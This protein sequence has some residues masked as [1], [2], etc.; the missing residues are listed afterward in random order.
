MIDEKEIYNL[1]FDLTQDG[2]GSALGISR[3]HSSSELKKLRQNGKIKEKQ[4]R[5]T[6]SNVRRKVYYLEPGGKLEAESIEKELENA[7]ISVETVLDMRRCDPEL[8]WEKLSESDRDALGLACVIRVP[9]YR[10][11]LPPTN[12]GVIPSTHEGLVNMSEDVKKRYLGAVSPELVR[13]WNSSAADWWVDNV[14]D[15]QER[16]YHLVK[17]GRSLEANRL[18]IRASESFIANCN[19]D[20]LEII[21]NMDE[22][23]RNP[24]A[25]WSLRGKIAVS[26][27]DSDYARV[28]AKRLTELGSD[29][30][31][32][33]EAEIKY[34]EGN[35]EDALSDANKIYSETKSAR[36]AMLTGR[37][38][39]AL[40]RYDDAEKALAGTMKDFSQSGDI[41]RLDEILMLR[42]GIAYN[43]EDRD[44]CI[45]LLSKALH[46]ARNK[47]RKNRISDIVKVV[48]SGR[49]EPVFD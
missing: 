25:A 38:L 9:V 10:D 40:E 28:C 39:F 33:L 12:P 7:G 49:I 11:T 36:A 37:S 23:D 24:F 17:A 26:C 13:K 21:Q 31:K 46:S 18:L 41:S 29:E 2:I 8:M 20:L 4:V 47:E 15:R 19:E 43:R 1:P 48:R 16:L 32:I 27:G 22:P 6:G 14:A 42:A 35:F 3:A 30:G 45:S 44:T 34:V 5:V